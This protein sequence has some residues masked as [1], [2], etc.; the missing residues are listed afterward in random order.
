MRHFFAGLVEVRLAQEDRQVGAQDRQDEPDRYLVEPQGDARKHDDKG[1][2]RADAH[3]GQHRPGQAAG[4]AHDGV[5]RHGGE[6]DR[7]VQR[8]VDHA[9]SLG[10]QFALSGDHNRS[11][12]AYNPRSEL[13]N[14]VISVGPQITLKG[15]AYPCSC[16]RL[17]IHTLKRDHYLDV[18]QP[19]QIDD[20]PAVGGVLVNCCVSALPAQPSN[21]SR[22]TRSG[23][24]NAPDR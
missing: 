4:I 24:S 22:S 10:Q 9:G 2:Q 20:F 14:P 15:C 6:H 17:L 21:T 23:N 5:R 12:G 7:A 18:R 16:F 11:G 1:H 19:A 13:S 8:Q 3:R